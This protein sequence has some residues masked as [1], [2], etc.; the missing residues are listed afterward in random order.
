MI[1][2]VSCSCDH[3]E[4]DKPLKIIDF[5]VP[6]KLARGTTKLCGLRGMSKKGAGKPAMTCGDESDSVEEVEYTTV[7][8]HPVPRPFKISHDVQ[9]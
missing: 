1:N 6:R 3:I 4:I 8:R 7:L 5:L 9:N 2:T